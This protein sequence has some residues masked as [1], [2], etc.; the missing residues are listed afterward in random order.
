MAEDA[1][2][3]RGDDRDDDG[4]DRVWRPS[5]GTRI[6]YG[7]IIALFALLSAAGLAN[8]LGGGDVGSSL[9]V[10]VV[11]A[12]VAACAWRWGSHPLI[13]ATGEGVT[14]R[15]PLRTVVV[16]WEDVTG[17]VATSHGVTIGHAGERPL[18]AWAVP[19]PTLS[20]WFRR[21]TRADEVVGYITTR[22]L[23]HQGG[24]L[25][26]EPFPGLGDE[27]FPVLG[28]EPFPGEEGP[29]TP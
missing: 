5:G 10:A 6:A 9:V 27:A 24:G 8:A 15:N 11:N 22:A 18:V 2:E 7:L 23:A 13:G 19:K 14:V 28:D 12:A 3:L 17:C 1:G 21:V 26:D 4:F 20:I 25:G 29:G 16:A